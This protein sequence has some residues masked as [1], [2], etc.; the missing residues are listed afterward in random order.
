MHIKRF[1][2]LICFL[3]LAVTGCKRS[4]TTQLPKGSPAAA[5]PANQQSG[6]AYFDVCGLITK[7]QIEAVMGSPI[8]ETKSSG[9]SDGAFRVSQCFYTAAEFSKSVSLAVTQ[10]DPNSPAKRSPKEFWEET[11][12]R[13]EGEEKEHEGDKEKKESLRE[14]GRGKGEEKEAAPPKKI[15][16]IG[17]EAFWTGNRFGGALYV[18]KKDTFIR[19]SVGGPDKEEAKIDKSKALAEKALQ[20]L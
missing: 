14:E 6:E 15:T 13:Y 17:D 2:F 18:L 8:K 20:R 19:I 7:E 1:I 9:R 4:T 10:N 16:G 3:L 11:F 12:G 5:S